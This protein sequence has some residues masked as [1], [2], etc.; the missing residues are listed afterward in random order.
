[1]VEYIRESKEDEIIIVYMRVK[2]EFK[3]IM[4]GI[5]CVDCLKRI[6]GP[7]YTIYCNFRGYF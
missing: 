3:L 2:I 1:M 5:I 7:K 4:R 6:Q